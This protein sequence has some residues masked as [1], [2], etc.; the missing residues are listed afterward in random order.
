MGRMVYGIEIYPT[1]GGFVAIKQDTAM[2]ENLVLIHPLQF[3]FS[4]SDEFVACNA[5]QPL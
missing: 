1:E 5:R 3:R 2:E 4:L